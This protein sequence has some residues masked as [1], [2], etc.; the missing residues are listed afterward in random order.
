MNICWHFRLKMESKGRVTHTT[1]KWCKMGM[2]QKN[3]NWVN[4][5]Q[6][7]SGFKLEE[8][9]LLR[10]KLSSTF[11]WSS[12]F[13][14]TSA[15]SVPIG[16]MYAIYGNYHQYTPNVSIYEYIYICHTW[17]L[18]G[19][20]LMTEV[21]CGRIPMYNSWMVTQRRH[22]TGWSVRSMPVGCACW[23]LRQQ[24]APIF[25]EPCSGQNTVT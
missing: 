11:R 20:G 9:D 4:F 2:W 10:R 5:G 13:C 15:A 19:V 23:L 8:C 17:I 7:W 24:V 25:R 6:G 14:I 12:S 1:V 21:T 16:S 22:V 3:M 18:W